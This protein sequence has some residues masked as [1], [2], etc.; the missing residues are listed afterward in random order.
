MSDTVGVRYGAVLDGFAVCLPP[1]TLESV[2]VV[3]RRR[4]GTP[5]RKK[6]SRGQAGGVGEG[7]G[8][9]MARVARRGSQAVGVGGA[10][11]T[12]RAPPRIGDSARFRRPG[13][14]AP[15]APTAP[16]S[17]AIKRSAPGRSVARRGRCRVVVDFRAM[18]NVSGISPRAGQNQAVIGPERRLS[19]LNPA[20]RRA[21]IPG[22][23]EW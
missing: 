1:C 18:E 23:L 17:T 11:Q 19:T 20:L 8:R 3:H 14:M 10:C 6:A 5:A 15:T 16:G 22:P 2:I 9:Q 21:L 7:M 13:A 4:Y 12:A